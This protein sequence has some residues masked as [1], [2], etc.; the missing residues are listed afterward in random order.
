ML[1]EGGRHEDRG[2]EGEKLHADAAERPDIPF[3]HHFL[4]NLTVAF[5]YLGQYLGR[6]VSPAVIVSSQ[7]KL[8]VKRGQ[9]EVLLI[10]D[11][12]SSGVKAGKGLAFLM[13]TIDQYF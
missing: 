13:Q 2:L 11:D 6:V 3:L 4:T 9:V 10:I 7:L 1:W 5:A 8:Q 12:D